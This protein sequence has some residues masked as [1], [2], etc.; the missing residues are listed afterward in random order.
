MR[1]PVLVAGGAGFLGYHLCARLLKEG[2]TV[3]VV[4]NLQTGTLANV[5]ALQHQWPNTCHF[6]RHDITQPLPAA[7]PPVAAVA[8]LACAASPPK[9][10][11]HPVHTLLTNVVGTQ[12]LLEKARQDE[13]RFLQA[14]TSE[15]YG[16]PTVHPQPETYWGNVNP[17]G[18][19][20]CYD[21]GKRA[22][23]ALCADYVRQFG[24]TVRLA[25]IFNT[26]GPRMAATDGRVITQF[27]AQALSGQPLTLYGSGKQTR[28]FCYVDDWV[29]GAMRLW[30]TPSLPQN[31]AVVNL[32]NPQ[33]WT[34]LELVATLETVLGRMLPVV[35]APLPQDDPQKRRPDIARA[36]QWL[37]WEP[38]VALQ[39]GL[40]CM[41]AAG[42]G[43]N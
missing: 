26:Y 17:L 29:E 42:L 30:W 1:K 43:T 19:R 35:H 6:V 23:E 11:A 18:P 7:L 32:G 22:A 27:L 15:I 2:W 14:S 33:E 5:A 12:H 31:P 21:E 28:S 36:R 13:A 34:L 16:D 9:Y 39:D 3:W 25:R 37:G 10:Q 8:N 4:D 38:Q 20:A 41:L 24:L 40:R